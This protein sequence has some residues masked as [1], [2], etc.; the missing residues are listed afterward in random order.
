MKQCKRSWREYFLDFWKGATKYP[1]GLIKPFNVIGFF[2]ETNNGNLQKIFFRILLKNG[3]KRTF[4]QIVFP[5]Q[6]AGIIKKTSAN[7][8]G[9][10]EFHV[11]FYADGTIDC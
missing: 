1:N 9:D 5:G 8:Q 7:G 2:P 10:N 4:W 3:F 11:R 6:I